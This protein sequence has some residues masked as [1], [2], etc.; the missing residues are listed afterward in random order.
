MDLFKQLTLPL[1][2]LWST[3]EP[4]APVTRPFQSEPDGAQNLL[5]EALPNQRNNLRKVIGNAQQVI[6]YELRRGKRRTIGFMIDDRGVTVS[7]PRWVS[8]S[9]ID[10]AVVEKSHWISRKLNE[11]RTHQERRLV[12]QIQWMNGGIMNYMGR[13]VTLKI[14]PA[15][16]GLQLDDDQLSIGLP[17]Q[18]EPERIKN[19]VQAWLQNEAR[20][21]FGQRLERLAM[22][23]G[24][25]PRR[26]TLSSARTRWGSCTSDG[27]IR[28]NWR[29]MHF[30]LDVI[31]YVIAHELAH[32]VE[33][34]HGPKFWEKV[35]QIIPNFQEARSQLTGITDDMS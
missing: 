16:V 9:E 2:D 6:E 3:P 23:T 28:L 33:M 25:A 22:L 32:L 14:C 18:A 7:A 30:P 15:Q 31:D 13:P 26:W 21:L 19:T 1:F 35:A 10:A 12:N 8:L 11:W 27:T 5:P 4:S 17:S 34:N 24:K 29:L 20:H